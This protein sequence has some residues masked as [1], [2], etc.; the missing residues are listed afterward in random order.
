MP[1]LTVEGVGSFGVAAD[2]RLV[3][4]LEDEAGIDQLHACGG[5]ARCT[6]CRV[7]FISG[8]PERMTEAEKAVL[9]ARGLNAT[10]GLR[11]SCQILCDHDMALRAISRL[12]GSGRRMRSRLRW[13]GPRDDPVMT[14]THDPQDDYELEPLDNAPSKAPA[15]RQPPGS[16]LPIPPEPLHLCPHCKYNLTG[17]TSRRC[18]ECGETF[19]LR[20]A[21]MAGEGGVWPYDAQDLRALRIARRRVISG[22]LMILLG[23][24]VP[25]AFAGGSGIVL[26]VMLYFFGP[27]AISAVFAR[28]MLDLGWPLIIFLLGGVAALVGTMA[29]LLMFL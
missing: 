12:A 23:L 5:N 19:E 1:Q 20:R 26:V 2:K 9:A 8:E 11:L 28:A 14:D 6:T 18:P 10:S 29:M 13:P 3:L 24:A 25:Y 16:L 22:A 7:Q 27:F 15:R 4:A 17:L 21:R